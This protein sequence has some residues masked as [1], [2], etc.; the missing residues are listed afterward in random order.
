MLN[1]FYLDIHTVI[2]LLFWVNVGLSFLLITKFNL[3]VDVYYKKELLYFIFSRVF[4]A[5]GWLLL[6]YRGII[7]EFLALNLANSLL[8]VGF[9][10]QVF[11]FFTL[12]KRVKFSNVFIV[13]V[14]TISGIVLLNVFSNE[15][16]STKMIIVTSTVLIIY[17]IPVVSAILS[18]VNSTYKLIITLSYTLLVIACAIRVTDL[19]LHP[20]Y[21]NTV[22]V[23]SNTF[24]YIMF[25]LVAVV[26]TPTFLFEFNRKNEVGLN[27]LAKTDSLTGLMN[28]R[29]LIIE[30]ARLIETH[31]QKSSSMAVLFLDIDWFKR[32]NDSQG[33]EIGDIIL[34]D[35]SNIL[36]NQIRDFD[37]VAR[38]GGEEFVVVLPYTDVSGTKLVTDRINQG[39]RESKYNYTVSIGVCCKTPQDST[40]TEYISMADKAMYHAKQNGKNKVIFC[41]ET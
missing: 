32:I 29:T 26:T 9:C 33:H 3:V 36:V 25:V 11:V 21:D 16:E 28:R 24:A 35:L 27:F 20:H 17:S 5:L 31:Q 30:M 8:L 14:S 23:F 7:S 22:Q 40:V 6:F 13:V 15:A 39:I 12:I 4:Q 10:L 37:I 18:K 41:K 34:Q 19:L 38:Y 2:G 1:I